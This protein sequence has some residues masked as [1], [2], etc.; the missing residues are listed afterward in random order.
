MKRRGSR[1]D[2]IIESH[3]APDTMPPVLAALGGTPCTR[4]FTDGADEYVE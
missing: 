4:H 2:S 1:M 3:H